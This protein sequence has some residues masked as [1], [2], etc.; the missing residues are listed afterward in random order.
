MVLLLVLIVYFGLMIMFVF[1]GMVVD[2]YW[3]S[4][5]LVLWRIFVLMFCFFLF[6]MV[7]FRFGG[8]MGFS[9]F[10]VVIY[11]GYKILWLFG[12]C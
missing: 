5:V 8:R 4:L 9:G 3:I 10:D 11:W 6:L 1:I 2:R 12:L 7:L